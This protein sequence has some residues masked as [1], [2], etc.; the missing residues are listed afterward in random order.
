MVT[1]IGVDID[2]EMFV[3]AAKEKKADIVGVSA[4]LTTTM[5]GM[6]DVI[7]SVREAGI[8]AKV[9]IG[10]ASITTEYADEIGADG[11]APDAPAA[12]REAAG[13]VEP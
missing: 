10:G 13:L 1:D 3:E 2:P 6:K 8:K 11:Y 12:V 7:D 5:V 4:L 9:M